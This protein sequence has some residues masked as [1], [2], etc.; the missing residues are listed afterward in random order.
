M[1]KMQEESKSPFN[2]HGKGDEN[3]VFTEDDGT[4]IQVGSD[5]FKVPEILFNPG[6]VQ[7]FP[8]AE[9]IANPGGLPMQR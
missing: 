7:T 2:L 5:R 9:A 6:L 4:E 3:W 1:Q 8:G